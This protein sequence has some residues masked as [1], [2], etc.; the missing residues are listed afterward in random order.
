M[1]WDYFCDVVADEM[2]CARSRISWSSFIEH[3][4]ESEREDM[5][6]IRVDFDGGR[7]EFHLCAVPFRCDYASAVSTGK[8]FMFML[9]DAVEAVKHGTW[10][11]TGFHRY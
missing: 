4:P 9:K 5:P 2:G 7:E 1:T 3:I 6:H 10:K 11:P 8:N